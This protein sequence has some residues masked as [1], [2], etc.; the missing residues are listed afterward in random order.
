M[1]IMA[2]TDAHKVPVTITSRA[3]IFT[4]KLAE[5]KVM[6][7]YLHEVVK[8]EKIKIGDDALEIIVRRGGGSFRDTLS[9]LDQ[10]ATLSKDTITK[11]MVVQAMGLPEEEMVKRLLDE[12]LGGDWSRI[13]EALRN[14][15]NFRK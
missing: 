3:Q 2:T 11:E 8:K 15:L 1:F 14:F 10:I 6:L 9:L 4:F 12:Y 13:T 7:D 5:P